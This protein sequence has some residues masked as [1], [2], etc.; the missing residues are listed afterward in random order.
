MFEPIAKSREERTYMLIP[1]LMSVFFSL[2]WQM[3][4]GGAQNFE[5]FRT[6]GKRWTFYSMK[7]QSKKIH[8]LFKVVF[9]S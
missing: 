4:S 6:D 3:S 9:G 5:K 8:S 7:G 1:L 2:D